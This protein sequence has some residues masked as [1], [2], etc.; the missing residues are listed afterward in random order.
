MARTAIVVIVAVGLLAVLVWASI[1]FFGATGD[2]PTVASLPAETESARDEPLVETPPAPDRSAAAPVVPEEVAPQPEAARVEAQPPEDEAPAAAGDAPASEQTEPPA[3]PVERT[4]EA[5]PP[6][7]ERKVEEATQPAAPPAPA[8]PVE[9]ARDESAVESKLSISEHGVGT[10]VENRQLVGRGDRFA[11]GSRVWFWTRVHG[12]SRGDTIEHVW[13]REG[14][15]M[16]AI[17]LN[18]GASHWRTQSHWTLP[19]GSTGR[20]SVEARDASGR[21]LAR[22]DFSCE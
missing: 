5:P 4:E 15:R 6:E 21:L 13:L 10:G 20:W 16:G 11:A 7:P 2:E 12:G 18:I 9:E 8:P 14:R 19:A 1:R 3:P 22:S 17:E